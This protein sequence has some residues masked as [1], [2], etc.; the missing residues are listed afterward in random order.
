VLLLLTWKKSTSQPSTS[1]GAVY[2][3]E[4]PTSINPV[5][6]LQIKA[7]KSTLT[8]LTIAQILVVIS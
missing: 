2:L 7:A 1:P 4:E 5:P 8:D 6:T 3:V